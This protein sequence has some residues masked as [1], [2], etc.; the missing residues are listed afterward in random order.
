MK[1]R[2][3]PRKRIFSEAGSTPIELVAWGVLLLLP[4]SGGLSVYQALFDQL[5]AES[6]ARHGLRAAVFGFQNG[7]G[8]E[9]ALSKALPYLELSWEK[10][11]SSSKLWCSGECSVGKLVNLEVR[12]GNAL[13]IQSAGLSEQ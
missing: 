1:C 12:I 5:A 7:S 2:L 10:Q 11:I 4:L 9:T 13:A 3:P 8:L 6:I